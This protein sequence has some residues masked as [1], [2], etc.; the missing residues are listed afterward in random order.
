MNIN[1]EIK[2]VMVSIKDTNDENTKEVLK[3]RLGVM[4]F[5]K[6]AFM[7]FLT[8]TTNSEKILGFKNSDNKPLYPSHI[9]KVTDKNG[10][11]V[12]VTVFD[13]DM[14][15]RIELLPEDVQQT[16]ITE[17]VRVRGKNID[18]QA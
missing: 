15:E 7:E 18:A 4:K 14:N 3:K 13:I 6:T 12:E 8:D 2:N 9:D 11:E 16:I 1:K 10:K 5:I 17:M